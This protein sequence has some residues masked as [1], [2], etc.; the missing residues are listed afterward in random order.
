VTGT[1]DSTSARLYV[2]GA[3]QATTASGQTVPNHTGPLTLGDASWG[4]YGMSGS[5]DEVA[6]YSTVLTG[7][8]VTEH[9]NAGRR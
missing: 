6:I 3:L 4:S 5:L 9:Y 1:Y 2:N 7:Q 8:Q